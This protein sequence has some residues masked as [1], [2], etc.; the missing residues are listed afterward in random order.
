M[1]ACN[2]PKPSAPAVTDAPVTDT[3]GENS[4]HLMDYRIE[5]N[6]P[7]IYE[8]YGSILGQPVD[9][10]WDA[11]TVRFFLN[12]QLIFTETG[13]DYIFYKHNKHW[14]KSIITQA[15]Q[16]VLLL[17]R[18]LGEPEGADI[19]GFVF[20]KENMLKRVEMN[21]YPFWKIDMSKDYGPEELKKMIGSHA[22]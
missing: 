17:E 18:S 15:G 5:H 21:T 11:D 19:I 4:H 9:T 2:P 7:G 14:P 3:S 10:I 20:E 12:E 16:T 13:T 8:S 22:L 1:A 6:N